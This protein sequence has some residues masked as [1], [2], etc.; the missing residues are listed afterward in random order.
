MERDE[1][2]LKFSY[3]SGDVGGDKLGSAVIRRR[4]ADKSVLCATDD[5]DK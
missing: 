5:D 1:F 3:R 2:R 4:K